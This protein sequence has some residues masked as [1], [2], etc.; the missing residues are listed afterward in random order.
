MVIPATACPITHPMPWAKGTAAVGIKG[1]ILP[2]GP[3][4]M[5]MTI[6]NNNMRNRD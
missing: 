3:I 4:T 6:N 1:E 5:N 2:T